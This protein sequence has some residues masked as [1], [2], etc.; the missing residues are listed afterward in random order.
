MREYRSSK[1]EERER[2]AHFSRREKVSFWQ[3]WELDKKGKGHPRLILAWVKLELEALGLGW[4][5]G[6]GGE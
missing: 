2:N 5:V 6:E 1:R 4:S 3:A